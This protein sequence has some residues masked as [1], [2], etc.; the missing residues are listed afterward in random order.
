[1]ADQSTVLN[2]LMA[3]SPEQSSEPSAAVD[4]KKEK[5]SAAD[6]AAGANAD[7]KKPAEASEDQGLNIAEVRQL[8]AG[9][10]KGYTINRQEMAEIR[11][12]LAEK[13]AP[14]EGND[15]Y[16][17][18]G[19]LREI[20]TEVLNNRDQSVTQ[21]EAQARQMLDDQFNQLVAEGLVKANEREE[22]FQHGLSIEEFQDMRKVA[23]SFALV[24]DAR[25]RREAKEAEDKIKEK[26]E[27]G[28]KVGSSE[29]SSASRG[30]S[31]AQIHRMSMDDI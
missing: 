24:R 3:K 5:E 10:Q 27:K 26:Q 2:E 6:G 18:V 23:R 12:L 13:Q 15:E 4:E 11:N 30:L 14:A 29:K 25:V 9:L 1:M 28:S 22:F 21:A 20:V 8:L 17:T 19:K 31:Y 16:V 7:D